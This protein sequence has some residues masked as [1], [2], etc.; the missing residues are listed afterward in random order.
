M[1]HERPPGR[2]AAR[3]G[4]ML[5]CLQLV[6]ACATQS[7]RS[8]TPSTQPSSA[9]TAPGSV[10]PNDSAPAAGAA[11]A[12]LANRLRVR[13]GTV[14]SLGDAP[15][16]IA[17]DRGYFTEAG[18]D[19]EDN[20]FDAATRMIAPVAA[21]QLDVI[22]P[23]ITAGLFN[24]FSRD[25]N[26]RIVADR[27]VLAHGFGYSGLVVRQDLWDSGALRTLDA[28]RGQRVG[29]AGFQAGSSVALLLGHAL[30]ARG[31]S[32]DDID[33]V[34]LPLPDTNVGLANGSLDAAMQI[35]PLI[36][37]GV[38]NGWFSVLQRSDELYPDQQNAFILYAADFAGN[39]QE[40]G[41]RWMVAYLRGVRDYLD[42]FVKNQGRDAVAAILAN[43][44]S[45]K[46]LKLYDQ[47]VPTYINPNGHLNLRTL[48]EAQ[49]WFAA[50]GYVPRKVDVPALIDNQFVDY[51]LRVLGE[52]Q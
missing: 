31:M 26:V 21:G 14:S 20:R 27:G 32:L 29:I 46:D 41:R 40:A 5:L 45:V 36:A 11:L 51:A 22:S 23:A 33:V 12:P 7:V 8:P 48:V 4:L 13:V 18:L 42:A 38:A 50:H 19:V 43:N 2:I 47:M 25:I 15:I 44:T 3:F 10:A 1:L 17:L 24:A 34:D 30:E 9:T 49:D 6:A 52:Y 16:Y 35:E 39:Q 37:L 28:L